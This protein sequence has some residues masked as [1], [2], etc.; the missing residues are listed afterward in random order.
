M[1]VEETWVRR[2]GEEEPVLPDGWWLENVWQ[3]ELVSLRC[4]VIFSFI[5]SWISILGQDESILFL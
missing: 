3:L 5:Y 4:L 2:M 1:D